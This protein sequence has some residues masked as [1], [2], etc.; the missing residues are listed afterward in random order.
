LGDGG[1]LR[2]SDVEQAHAERSPALGDG[3]V[4]FDVET[5]AL[6]L[7]LSTSRVLEMVHAELLPATHIGGRWWLRRSDVEQAAAA[8]AFRRRSET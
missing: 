8:R 3:D 7:E 5:T 1:W 2:R 6:V 4:T